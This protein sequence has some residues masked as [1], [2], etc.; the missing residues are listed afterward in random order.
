METVLHIPHGEAVSIG[1]VAASRLS[2][3]R[4]L[5][6]DSDGQRIETLLRVFGLPVKGAADPDLLIDALNKDKK[7]ENQTI[8]FVLLEAIGRAT[9]ATVDLEEL[10]EVIHDLCQS[11]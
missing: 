7:R 10:R 11:R 9:V 8:H 3:A 4:K 2:V 1:M 6:S 5:L